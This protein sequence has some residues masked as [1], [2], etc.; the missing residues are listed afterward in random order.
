MRLTL[1]TDYA[2][3]TLIFL[4]SSDDELQ[5]VAAI[6]HTYGMPHSTVMKIVSELVRLNYIESV[7]GRFGGIR[8][9]MQPKDISI[10]E[11]VRQMEE[12]FQLAECGNCVLSPKCRLKGI[13][14]EAVEAFMKVLDSYSLA[15]L[16]GDKSDIAELLGLINMPQ[17][18][19]CAGAMK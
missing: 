2:L 15:E 13:F 14:R 16:I 1:F 5:S 4:G 11:V 6:S 18:I 19:S 9:A 17:P 12:S 8:L 3:R 7:R 10:G